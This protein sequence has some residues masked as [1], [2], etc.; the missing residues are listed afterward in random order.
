MKRIAKIFNGT[1]RQINVTVVTIH[2][3]TAR[4]KFNTLFIVLI[5]KWLFYFDVTLLMENSKRRN[6]ILPIGDKDIL[7]FFISSRA[8]ARASSI[9]CIR[10]MIILVF[11]IHCFTLILIVKLVHQP[12]NDPRFYP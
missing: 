5:V 10:V 1:S 8:I 7:S 9:S 4:I 11:V 12:G 3:I 6:S 2:A